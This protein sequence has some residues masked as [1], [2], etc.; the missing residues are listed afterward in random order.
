MSTVSS[1]ARERNEEHYRSFW[2]ETPDFLRYNPGAR[3]RRRIVLR[4]LAGTPCRSVLDVG[5]GDGTLLRCLREAR[6]DVE[7]W[8]GADLS[9]EQVERN[10]RRM[11]DVAFHRLDLG[12][13]SLDLAFDVVLCSEVIEHIDEQPAAVRHLAAMVNPGGRLVLTCPTGA[14]YA[15]ERHFG[16]VHHPTASELAA[17]ARDAGLSL[18]SITTWGWPTYSTLKW[19]TNVNSAWSL[20]NFASGRYSAAAKLVSSGIYL[21]TYLNKAN[22]SR[23]CQL[24]GVFEKPR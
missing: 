11:P 21:A 12:R 19:A 4:L 22:D 9:P 24:F 10:R 8:A 5:C 2:E 13:E 7:A 3:H 23:G 15:T 18:V 1:T 16:H 6:P 14:M 17:Y 20:R